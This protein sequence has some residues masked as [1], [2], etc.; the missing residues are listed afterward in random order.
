MRTGIELVVW[1]MAHGLSM[2]VIEDHIAED[3][4][5]ATLAGFT[6]LVLTDL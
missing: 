2:L 3:L 6:N 5:S 1:S 4:V